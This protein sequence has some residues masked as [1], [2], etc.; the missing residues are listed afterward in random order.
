MVSKGFECTTGMAKNLVHRIS[1]KRIQQY[2]DLRF[3][4]FCK[5]T[6]AKK[7][8]SKKSMLSSIVSNFFI[9]YTSRSQVTTPA[10]WEGQKKGEAE[11]K[12]CAYSVQF[13]RA[14]DGER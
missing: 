2:W 10:F 8:S 5:R 13:T 9:D 3:G 4:S 12:C 7:Q 11:G 14:F 6:E 1:P